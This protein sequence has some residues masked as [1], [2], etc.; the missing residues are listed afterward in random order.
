MNS[1][2][3]ESI[4]EVWRVV[5]YMAVNS[6]Q[7]IVLLNDGTHLCTCLLLVSH[8]IV[9]RHYFKLMVENSNALF[10]VMLMPKRWL[11]DSAW[12]N[13]DLVLKESFIGTSSQTYDNI[14]TYP[15]P[16]HFDNIQEIQVRKQVQKKID[17]GRLMGHFKKA[18]NYS[19]EDDD[20]KN[21][22]DII[23]AYIFEREAQYDAKTRSEK[24]NTLNENMSLGNVK[25]SDGSIY[26][27]NDIKNPIKRQ[28]KGRPA[29]RLKA[30]DEKYKAGFSKAQKENGD[31][32]NV[33]GRRCG[34]CHEIG[35]YAPKCPNRNS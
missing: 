20:Q 15:I 29:K 10:H 4:K 28:G 18:L 27:I 1:V 34:L 6:Y 14:I 17:Y 23:L 26:D 9:C 3:K 5:P 32:E 22:D 8:G 33:N 35:H 31:I 2:S 25:S 7:H 16:K 11:Q 30:Y 12:N 21:L 13:I 19:L 24:R